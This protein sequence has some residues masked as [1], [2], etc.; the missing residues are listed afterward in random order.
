MILGPDTITT[1]AR[2]DPKKIKSKCLD[3]VL[4]SLKLQNQ[5]M[6]QKY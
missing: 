4:V 2:D 6:I 1:N 5:I 3:G